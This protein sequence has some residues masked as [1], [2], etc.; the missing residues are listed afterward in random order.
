MK[1][2]RCH[3]E[4]EAERPDGCE[5][6]ACPYPEEMDGEEHLADCVPKRVSGGSQ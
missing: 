6:F 3:E 2:P 4:R 5:D 1:C